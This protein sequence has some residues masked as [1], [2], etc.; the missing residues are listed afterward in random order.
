VTV[1][2]TVFYYLSQPLGVSIPTPI[3]G[4]DSWYKSHDASTFISGAL[5]GVREAQK[6]VAVSTTLRSDQ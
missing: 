1:S 6:Y 5:S 4:I 2:R 3:A